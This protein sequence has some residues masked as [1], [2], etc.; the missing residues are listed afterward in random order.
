MKVIVNFVSAKISEDTQWATQFAGQD[1]ALVKE[2]P[3]QDW[4]MRAHRPISGKATWAAAVKG[5]SVA[6]QVAGAGGTVL[7][8]SGHSGSACTIGDITDPRCRFPNEGSVTL[9]FGGL[10]K[11]SH[12]TVFYRSTFSGLEK[13]QEWEDESTLWRGKN[14]KEMTVPLIERNWENTAAGRKKIRGFYDEIGKVLRVN[15][16][17]QF[18][19]LSCNLGNSLGMVQQIAKDWGVEVGCYKFLTTVLPGNNLKDGKARFILARDKAKIGSGTNVEMARFDTPSFLD[20][21][22]ALLCQP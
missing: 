4:P 3:Y 17:K 10:V 19:I 15:E 9:D 21:T 6:A 2:Y 12:K 11:F 8:L 7:L 14:P 13:S 16:V 5:I 1:A 18:A 20:T 22:I